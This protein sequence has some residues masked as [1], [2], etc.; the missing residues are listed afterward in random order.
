MTTMC[1]CDLQAK[2]RA[3]HYLHYIELYNNM[4]SKCIFF[5]LDFNNVLIV[6]QHGNTTVDNATLI[7]SCYGYQV[8]HSLT[9]FCLVSY[10]HMISFWYCQALSGSQSFRFNIHIV[11]QLYIYISF[12][13]KIVSDAAQFPLTDEL[14]SYWSNC[15]SHSIVSWKWMWLYF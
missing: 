13:N 10:H 9:L 15:E 8:V 4:T 6:T 11:F 7:C 5:L 3:I 14:V 2:N 12:N 1:L